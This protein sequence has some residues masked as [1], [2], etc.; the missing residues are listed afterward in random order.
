M[1]MNIR[2]MQLADLNPADY[3]PR[4]DLQPDD[5]IYLKIK[6]SLETFGMVEP[7]IWNERTGTSWAATRESRPCAIWAKPKPTL[8]S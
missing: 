6:Q 2:R 3:N 4:K 8:S 5:P 1:A 7:I